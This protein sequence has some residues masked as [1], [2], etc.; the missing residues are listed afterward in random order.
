MNFH[1]SSNWI[2]IMALAYACLVKTTNRNSTYLW[3][4]EKTSDVVPIVL[5]NP[6]LHCIHEWLPTG[7]VNIPCIYVFPNAIQ[8]PTLPTPPWIYKQN[9]PI[10]KSTTV[11]CKEPVMHLVADVDH[12]VYN[13]CSPVIGGMATGRLDKLKFPAFQVQRNWLIWFYLVW[14]NLI[15]DTLF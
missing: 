9:D 1:L 13:F 3:T 11:V 14:L 4:Q 12:A 7:L 6:T 10:Q 5:A 15:L 8:N 2:M